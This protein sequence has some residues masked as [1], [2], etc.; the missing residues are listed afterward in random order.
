MLLR[1]CLIFV[2]CCGLP[3]LP[4]H[5][6]RAQDD[7]SDGQNR[8]SADS[9]ADSTDESKPQRT[10]N[11]L[12]T[13]SSPYLL[14]HAHNPV[15][16]YPWGDEA[17]AKAKRENKMIFLSVGYAACHWCHVMERESFED[18]EIAAKLN[19]RFVCIKV[20]REERP[21]V[22]QVYMTA[23]QLISG[24]GGWPMSVFLLPDGSPFW[25]GTYFPARDGDRGAATGFL[26]VI[27]QIDAAWT[28]QED[29]VKQQAAALT[30]AVKTSQQA[31]RE[32]GPPRS[33]DDDL[34]EAVLDALRDQYDPVH[35]GFGSSERGPK[36]PEPSNLVFLLNRFDVETDGSTDQES[37]Q[38][39][40]LRTLDGMISGGM[41]DHLGGGFHRYS[42][43]EGWRIPHFEK[44]LYDNAQLV[45][46]FA[47]AYER[48]G[49]QEY[50]FI[51]EGTCDFL[52]RELKDAE[53]GFYSSLDADSEQE[54]GKY[55]RWTSEELTRLRET[56]GY[57]E[58][59]KV[60]QLDGPPNFENEYFVLD[61]RSPLASI[62]KENGESIDVLL[63]RF[64][65]IRTSMLQQRS[66]RIRP[67]TDTKI[68]TAWNGLMIAALADAG[69]VL[70]RKDYTR[71][72]VDAMSFLMS[73][74]RTE[75]GRLLRSYARGEAKLSGY[76]DDYA[77][78]AAGTIALHR[79][80]GDER[81]LEIAA[82]ITDTQIQWFWD[83]QQGG[84]FFTP[85]D[86]PEVIVRLKDPV[87]SALPS[88]ISVTAEN[89]LYLIEQG[90]DRGYRDRLQKTLTSVTPL[91][92]RAPG[93]V[94]RSAAV[95]S[96]FLESEKK[97]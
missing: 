94:P 76:L 34:V 29:K 84:F 22:D 15:D 56:E 50:R 11:R 81:L 48:T 46:V 96:R 75:Q 45:S 69:R 2:C 89:L 58:F 10:A 21:D 62:A 97:P 27:K 9:Q 26:T 18:E 60:Y 14:Q 82:Q 79:A 67:T 31:S 86:Q 44:M 4:Q 65:G 66:Q 12:A 7:L 3:I 53:G 59:A 42:V 36:F 47:A 64:R 39:M 73:R 43:D 91:M 68:L 8:Q 32:G 13:E 74:S 41:Y 30:Q 52:L 25:G 87:D 49:N 35:G 23:V 6:C 1:V 93:A 92:Q 80:L 71:A 40:L 70:Q 33:P 54:E 88:G 78:L 57:S 77:F 95:V 17:F 24:N 85:R 55:Y 63:E 37:A 72:A 51:I 20:D 83:E 90:V 5:L 61:P 16:W 38:S 28:S 19:E